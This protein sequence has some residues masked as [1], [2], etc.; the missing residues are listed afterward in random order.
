MSG[1]TGAPINAGFPGGGGGPGTQGSGGL[2]G[3]PGLGGEAPGD[4]GSLAIGGGSPSAGANA[5]ARGGGGGG[6]YFGGGGGGAGMGAGGGG[7]GSS[8]FGSTT[9]ARSNNVDSTGIPQVTIASGAPDP[10]PGPKPPT[11]FGVGQLRLNKHTGTAVLAVEVPAPGTVT[12]LGRGL[13][14]S[15]PV[16]FPAPGEVKLGVRA[17]G[18]AQRRLRRGGT[19]TRNATVT[20]IPTGGAAINK[21]AGIVLVRRR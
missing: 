12:L 15:G 16:A 21:V 17:T 13:T 18:R 9:R 1:Q 8:F 2:G 20:Y 5:G 19:I 3:S 14:A 10:L 4:P 11:D 6:G 7:G